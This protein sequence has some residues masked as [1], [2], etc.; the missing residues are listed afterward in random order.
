MCYFVS[1]VMTAAD[2][3]QIEHDFVLN[4]QEEEKPEP[5]YAVSGFVHPKLPVLTSNKEF[6]SMRWG[7]IPSWVKDWDSASKLRVNTLNAIGETIDSKPSFRGAVKNSRCCIIPVTGFFEWHHHSNKEKYPHY[8]YP[9]NY[10]VFLFA[11]LYEH[12]TNPSIGEVHETFTICTTAANERME[13]LHNSK[14][15]M[16]AILNLSSAKLWLDNDVAPDQKRKLLNP[17]DVT[18][19]LDHP[20]SKLITSRK[21][22]PNQAAVMDAVNYPE[23]A[24]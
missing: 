5:Y 21:E 3:V 23:L 6:K 24:L 10:P 16:P 4:W 17:F 8:I 20:V 14:K 9:K 15:R 18:E 22:N 19:M 7:L 12:W 1:N 2:F 11:G 13:W